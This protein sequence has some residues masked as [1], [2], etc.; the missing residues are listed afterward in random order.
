M[1]ELFDWA[2]YSFIEG[3]GSFWHD[4]KYLFRFI[5]AGVIGVTLP[6]WIIPYAIYKHMKQRG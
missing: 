3:C 1:K 2:Y 5:G 6:I 4:I